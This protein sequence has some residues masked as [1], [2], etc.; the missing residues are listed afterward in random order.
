[1]NN[2]NPVVAAIEESVKKLPFKFSE[3]DILII[4]EWAYT[5]YQDGWNNAK[6]ILKPKKTT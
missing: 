3:D 5:I 6:I 2:K 1:M 4:S